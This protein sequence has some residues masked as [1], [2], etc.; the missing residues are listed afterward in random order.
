M[1]TSALALFALSGLV[2]ATP[3]AAASNCV[4]DEYDHNGSLV[5]ARI[6]DRTLDITYLAPKASLKRIGVRRGTLL[7]QGTISR[8]GAVTA[9]AYVFKSGCR[10]ASYTVSGAIRQTSIWLEG[11]APVRNSRCRVS[12]YRYDELLFTLQSSSV[13]PPISR[14]RP[15]ANDWYAIAGAFGDFAGA[16]S[17][18]SQLGGSWAVKNTNDCP[19]FTPGYWIAAVGPLSQRDAEAWKS[20]ARQYGAYIKSCH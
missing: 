11:D 12:R 7:I 4:V 8:I 5:K 9:Q 6:C 19:N 14:P 15:Q 10:P 3:Q 13:A 18:V 1:R 20:T 16:A 2:L 17:R